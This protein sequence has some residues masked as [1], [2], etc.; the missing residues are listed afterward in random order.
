MQQVN[1]STKIASSTP[2]S[3]NIE[4]EQTTAEPSA[5]P[6]VPPPLNSV[7]QSTLSM[8]SNRTLQILTGMTTVMVGMAAVAGLTYVV[9]GFVMAQLEVQQTVKERQNSELYPQ[10]FD[11]IKQQNSGGNIPQE[12]DSVVEISAKIQLNHAM[13]LAATDNL[14]AA[15]AEA[16]NI[17]SSSLFYQQAQPFIRQW[18]E[19]ILQQE[20]KQRAIQQ[21]LQAEHENNQ[22]HLQLAQQ[23]LA[24]NDW[25]TAL[26][27]ARQVSSNSPWQQR[28]DAIVQRAEPYEYEQRAKQFLDQDE[29]EN[30]INEA[31][32]LPLIAPW[33]EKKSIIIAQARQRLADKRVATKWND[34]CREWA[35]SNISRCPNVE[36]IK[37]IEEILPTNWLSKLLPASRKSKR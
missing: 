34:R 13:Q 17:P 18:S 19:Q 14:Q 29:L 25:A 33:I 35:D 21:K 16:N 37:T 4:P 22:L 20:A 23:A 7:S 28:R 30:A 26:Q 10:Q 5:L 11:Q 1:S 15:I 31:G 27:E 12:Q 6:A 9:T 24:K 8:D 3:Q 32:K 36:D 2:L